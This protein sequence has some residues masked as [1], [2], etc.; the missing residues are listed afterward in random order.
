MLWTEKYFPKS[1]EEFVGNSDA[2]EGAFSW[3]SK[4]CEST[5]PPLLLWGPT[6]TGKTCLAYLIANSFGWSVVETNSSDFRSKELVE[7]IVGSASQ[8]A[9]FFG[10]K[11]LILI[12]DVDALTKNDRGGASAIASILKSIKNPVIL[13][14][15]DIYSNKSIS[16]L[17]FI[18]KTFEFKKINYV[19]M[20]NR[21]LEILDLEKIMY[22]V[23]AVKELAKNSSGDMR[24]ALLDLQTLSISGKITL[25]SVSSLGSRE[26]QQK[27]FNVMKSIFK[28]TNFMEV[29]SVRSQSDLSNDLIF[30]WVEENIPRQY[31]NPIDVALAFNRLSRADVFNGRIFRRQNWVFLRYSTELAAEGV[32][33]SKQ[34]TYS[35]FVMYQFPSI[36]SF[37]SKT[38]GTR[39]LK[40]N[41]CKKIGEKT[42]SSSRKV[43]SSDLP[44][45]KQVFRDT[46][47]AI[48][49]TAFF[50]LDANELSVLLD[51]KP[52]SKKIKNIL[53]KA[54]E[55]VTINST[56]KKFSKI[57]NQVEQLKEDDLKENQENKVEQTKLF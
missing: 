55:I 43:L 23:E 11:R 38:S 1:K 29:R 17:R 8:N 10:S 27:I 25:G 5:Q 42:H 52:D 32:A 57:E 28:G 36:L 20:A 31:S 30:K 15:N 51:A 24:S 49:L 35:D 22:D 3:A 19:S 33:L 54:S 13:T 39:S 12:D 16:S 34:K 7:K 4:W 41:L 6:G 50:D 56:Q 47:K 9:T 46:D 45:L 53:E 21:L 26:R 2:V 18:C 48:V 37:L 44:F 14:A 40:K